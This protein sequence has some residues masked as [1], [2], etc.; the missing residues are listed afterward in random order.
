[1]WRNLDVDHKSI[2]AS[3][4]NVAVSLSKAAMRRCSTLQTIIQSW[5]DLIRRPFNTEKVMCGRNRRT[6]TQDTR[7]STEYKIQS[8]SSTAGNENRRSRRVK[9]RTRNYKN[10]KTANQGGGGITGRNTRNRRNT[11]DWWTKQTKHLKNTG[12]KRQE[13]IYNW[14]TGEQAKRRQREE[15]KSQTGH[16]REFQ[17]KTGNNLTRN[18]YHDNKMDTCSSVFFVLNG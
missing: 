3:S 11:R 7:K 10:A 13:L 12:L 14:I 18:S 4:C 9:Q 15:V 2:N 1:M 17:N 8:P 16:M 5:Y 6:Q